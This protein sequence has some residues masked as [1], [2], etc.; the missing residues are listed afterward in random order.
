MIPALALVALVTLSVLAISAVTGVFADERQSMKEMP[1]FKPK[2]TTV[3][4]NGRTF[5][6]V[7][8]YDKIQ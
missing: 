4:E 2:I 5:E 3:T 1:N 7:E 6:I 8:F